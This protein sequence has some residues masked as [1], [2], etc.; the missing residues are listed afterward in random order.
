MCSN[1][2]YYL[3]SI[4]AILLIALTI[5]GSPLGACRCAEP[6]PPKEA[7]ERADCVFLGQLVSYD[8]LDTNMRHAKYFSTATPYRHIFTVEKIW[9]GVVKDTIEVITS[10]GGSCGYYFRDNQRYV[11]Y[12]YK[13]F[14]DSTQLE[15]SICSR[16]RDIK[17]ASD[18]LKELG[19]GIK[20]K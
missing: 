5:Y 15:T 13:S 2:R 12:A 1:D 4:S 20:V 17:S 18:D 16:T 14:Q 10:R 3:Y 11:I 6:K 19:E 9:K 8:Y 7:F